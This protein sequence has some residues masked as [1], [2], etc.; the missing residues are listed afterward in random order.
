MNVGRV[1]TEHCSCKH[2]QLTNRVSLVTLPAFSFT[3]HSLAERGLFVGLANRIPMS[4]T[5]GSS[6]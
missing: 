5:N 6:S 1:H 2:V 3:N 4:L